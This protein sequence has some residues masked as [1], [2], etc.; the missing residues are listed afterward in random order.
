[1]AHGGFSERFSDID[2]A[3]VL[4]APVAD[5]VVD[6]ARQQLAVLE[7]LELAKRVSLFWTVPD[8]PGPDAPGGSG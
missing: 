8:F 6:T 7:P 4:S 5:E 2:L 1:M 3:V